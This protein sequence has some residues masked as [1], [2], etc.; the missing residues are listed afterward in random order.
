[1]IDNRDACLANVI[2]VCRVKGS[3][4]QAGE[5]GAG[6]KAGEQKGT[7]KVLVISGCPIEIG[8]D[9]PGIGGG[10]ADGEA[11]SDKTAGG[12]GGVEVGKEMCGYQMVDEVA[13]E[14][15]WATSS[16]AEGNVV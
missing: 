5:G 3:D 13:T 16:K 1:M 6:K 7:V 4:V 8:G 12:L 11:A 10:G 2:A 9:G 14:L 15:E